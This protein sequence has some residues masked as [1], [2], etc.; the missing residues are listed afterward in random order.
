MRQWL[1]DWLLQGLA[2]VCW[3]ACPWHVDAAASAACGGEGHHRE[4][5]NY[6]KLCNAGMLLLQ[7]ALKSWLTAQAVM[8]F[9]SKAAQRASLRP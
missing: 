4:F 2:G 1:L 3:D 9:H 7:G 5:V 6:T 8:R